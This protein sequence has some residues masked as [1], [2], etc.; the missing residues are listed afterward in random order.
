MNIQVL[1]RM[2]VTDKQTAMFSSCQDFLDMI[3]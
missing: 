2:K 1:E 3:K